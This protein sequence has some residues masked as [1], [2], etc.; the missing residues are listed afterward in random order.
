MP[1]TVPNTHDFAKQYDALGWSLVA[2]PA[3]SK[4]PQTF[5]WQTNPTPSSFWE[6]HPT[7]NI[8]LLHSK[9]NTVA[10]DIDHMLNTRTIFE[11]LK[12][13]DPVALNGRRKLS[14]M[15]FA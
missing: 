6:S 9:S 5:S 13:N 1:D 3:G 4:A 2:I 7:H 11:A 10:L 14:S 8:G 15:I 12:P